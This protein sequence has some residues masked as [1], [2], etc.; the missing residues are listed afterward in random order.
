MGDWLYNHFQ[1]TIC[2]VFFA[3]VGYFTEIQGAV[4]VMW[5]A[6]AFDLITGILASMVKR[7]EK[8]CMSKAF[9]AIGRAI[10]ATALIALLYAM[11]KEMHQEV[12]ATYNVAAWLI[13]GFYAWSASE[14]MDDLFGGKLFR[15]LKDFFA[16]RVED[17]TGIQLENK[18]Y[19]H[20]KGD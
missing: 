3:I 9:T 18:D 4:H 16:K 7:H 8:F 5:A 20:E 11:D 6:L 17:Q 10:G 15:I 12:A 1:N 19:Q 14:N 2:A 13:C